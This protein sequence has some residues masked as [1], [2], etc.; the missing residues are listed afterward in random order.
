[1]A[2]L[3][4]P[5]NAAGHGEVYLTASPSQF[6]TMTY[7]YP[8]KL[9]SPSPLQSSTH[10]V[11]AIFLLTYGGGIVA[12]DTIYLNIT[13]ESNTRLIVLT[14]G[15]T[16]IF[17]TPDENLISKQQVY[18]HL[19][20]DSALCYIP[21]PVQPFAD[22]AFEQSQT[23]FLDGSNA[24]LCAA[25]WVSGGRTARGEAWDFWRYTSRNEI[26]G[27]QDKTGKRR[28]LL[29]DNIILDRRKDFGIKDIK[30]RVDG[31]GIMCTLILAGPVFKKL[32]DFFTKEFNDMPRIGEKKWDDTEE[33]APSLNSFEGRRK[34]RQQ[35]EKS[36]GV[37]W[38]VA[39]VR[40]FT[41]VKFGTR[42]VEGAKRWLKTMI[43]EDG[44]VEQ[45]FGDRSIIS[46]N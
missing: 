5:S 22:S 17:K 26:W 9:I 39:K 30:A 8:L 6:K 34:I 36:D 37:L 28:L 12:G 29:R 19:H 13:L 42:N 16:K 45:E 3:F 7:A 14:Q 32:S 23:Y 43:H 31:L 44:S 10:T 18:I 38:T 2:P 11:H 21:D 24:S 4:P 20:E 33:V 25:D 15:S 41:L 35:Q 46:L 27:P 1:M 40:N